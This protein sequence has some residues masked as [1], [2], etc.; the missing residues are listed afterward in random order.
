MPARA[1]ASMSPSSEN[2]ENPDALTRR[3]R[4]GLGR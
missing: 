1:S 3:G 4:R 2:Q